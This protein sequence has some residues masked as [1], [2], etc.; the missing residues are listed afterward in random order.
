MIENKELGLD[1]ILVIVKRRLKSALL[2]AILAPV[3]GFLVS[4]AFPPKYTAQSVILVEAPKMPDNVLPEAITQALSDRVSSIKTQIL[5]RSQLLPLVQRLG[6]AK[7]GR[8]PE[9]AMTDIRA[10]LAID[11]VISDA[12]QITG[13][14]TGKTKTAPKPNATAPA[15]TVS[16]TASNSEEARDVCT[17][18]TSMLLEENIKEREIVVRGTTDFLSGQLDDAKRSLDEQ[19]AKLAE[20]KKEY[21]GQLPGDE[22]TNLK[23]LAALETQLDANTQTINRAQ[24]DKAFAESTLSQ[25][26]A[27]WKSSQGTSNPQSLQQQLNQL[28]AQLLS[29]QARYTDDHPD[30][31]KTK[32]DIAEVKKRL[33][34]LNSAAEQDATDVSSD[35]ASLTEPPEIRQLRLQVHQYGEVLAQATREQK[36]VSDDIR[37]Y[38]SRVAVSPEVEAKYKELT[39]DYDTAQKMYADLLTK[40][41]TSETVRDAESRQLGEQMRLVQPAGAPKDPS[42]PNRYLFA[43]AGL[44]AG[45]AAGA[46]IALWQELR[47]K[48]I[49]DERDVEASLEMPVLVSIPWVTEASTAKNGNGSFWNRSKAPGSSSRDRVGV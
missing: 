20:F 37:R 29:L 38:Q 22:D 10:N 45:L 30:V 14:T 41:S 18:L 48:A 27:A 49:R 28:Q 25:Q 8:T 40:K 36:R 34:E 33:A 6:L 35:K 47:D 1:D 17:E 4:Y 23:V 42:F 16:F 5:G 11:P 32:A 7:N 24:Q 2:P 21:S 44:A 15:F 43:A 9:M 13:P 26:L 31:I 19:D 3:A 39:R 46:G 12:E